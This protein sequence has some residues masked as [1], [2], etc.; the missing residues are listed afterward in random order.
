MRRG[1]LRSVVLPALAV[2]TALVIGAVG[3]AVGAV[4]GWYFVRN[5]NAIE[6]WL[7]RVFG[8]RVW[9]RKV[10]AFDAI[11]NTVDTGDVVFIVIAA[12]AAA[13]VGATIPALRAA[14]M[15]P[16]EALRYE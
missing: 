14:K 2:F 12:M 7:V 16:V 3:S 9:D 13:I 15:N 5:I 11:P 10:Y 4:L 6:Q 1:A 8:W